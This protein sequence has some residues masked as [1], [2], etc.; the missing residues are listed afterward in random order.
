[1]ITVDGKEY[2]VE[3]T[4]LG[5][6][7]E[8]MYKYAERTEQ[9][10]LQYELGAV[11]FNQNITFGMVSSGNADFVSLFKLLSTRSSIDSGTGHNVEIWTPMGRMTF[12]MYPNK[13]TLNLKMIEAGINR[14]WWQGFSVKFIAVKPVES[15]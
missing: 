8:F 3:V 1:M 15:W 5:L 12:L 14:T 4:E 11:Y 10:D 2:N 7:V 13:L 9:Y 6:D